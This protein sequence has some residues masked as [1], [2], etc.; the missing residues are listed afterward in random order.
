MS[1]DTRGPEAQEGAPKHAKIGEAAKRA[2]EFEEK[3]KEKEKAQETAPIRV[4]G[5]LQ[6]PAV[7]IRVSH[8]NQQDGWRQKKKEKEAKEKAEQEAKENEGRD[9]LDTKD[10]ETLETKSKINAEEKK[11]LEEEEKKKKG[12]AKITTIF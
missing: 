5:K 3:A 4:V 10:K 9:E 2:K 7:D 8:L 12:K 1:A 6:T 11:K